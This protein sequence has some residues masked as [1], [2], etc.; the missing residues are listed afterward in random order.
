M[1]SD[2]W[3][4]ALAVQGA[5]EIFRGARRGKITPVGVLGRH[6]N[7]VDNARPGYDVQLDCIFSSLF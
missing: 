2:A 1:G 4:A 7:L 3:R 5:E 6:S